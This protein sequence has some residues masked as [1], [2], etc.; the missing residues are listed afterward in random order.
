MRLLALSSSSDGG[1][2]KYEKVLSLQTRANPRWVTTANGYLRLPIF[3]VSL[4]DDGE[5]A[6]PV[7]VDSYIISMCMTLFLLINLQPTTTECPGIS[8]FQRNL[9]LPYREIDSKLANRVFK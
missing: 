1:S 9:L 8:F 7:K 2:R 5:R 6:K 4:F 3:D